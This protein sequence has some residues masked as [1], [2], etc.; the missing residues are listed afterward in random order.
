MLQLV[1][2]FV[3]AGHAQALPGGISGL[4]WLLMNSVSCGIA[5]VCMP[6]CVIAAVF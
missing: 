1:S 2:L 6:L 3:V 5:V 4:Q